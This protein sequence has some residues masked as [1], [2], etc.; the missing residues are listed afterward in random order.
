MK[1]IFLDWKALDNI[2]ESIIML[3][4]WDFVVMK[5][6]NDADI[7]VKSHDIEVVD[8]LNFSKFWNKTLV[9]IQGN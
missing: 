5:Y 3:S 6:E 1:E 2:W 4:N 9:L 8:D 7:L